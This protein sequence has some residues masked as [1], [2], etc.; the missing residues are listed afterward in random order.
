[1]YM[2]QVKTLKKLYPLIST[3]R[4]GTALSFFL[5]VAKYTKHIDCF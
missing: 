2:S 1:M 4:F 5:H 3:D